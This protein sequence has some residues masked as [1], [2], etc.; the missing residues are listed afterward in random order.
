MRPDNKD[1]A[2]IDLY[3][4]QLEA[5]QVK[6][7]RIRAERDQLLAMKRRL[8]RIYGGDDECDD[9]NSDGV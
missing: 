6:M 5:L 7:D 2:K 9:N 4:L 1:R 8:V 3:L